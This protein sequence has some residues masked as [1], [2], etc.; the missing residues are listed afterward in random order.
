L[1]EFLSKSGGAPHCLADIAVS[2]AFGTIAEGAGF[3]RS[4]VSDLISANDP[5]RQSQSFVTHL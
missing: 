3:V 1:L 2:T 5:Q 4:V